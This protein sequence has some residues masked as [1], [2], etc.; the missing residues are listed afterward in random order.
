MVRFNLPDNADR[1]EASTLAKIGQAGRRRIWRRNR[2]GSSHPGEIVKMEKMLVRVDS[3]MQ[4]LPLDYNENDSLKTSSR[5]VE[6]WREFVVVCRESTTN[7]ADFSIQMYKTRVIPSKVDTKVRNRSTHEIPLA[8]KTTHVNL[9]SS[10]D[11]TLVIWV[12]WKMGTMMYILRT[13]S[14]ASAVEWYTFIRNSLGSHRTNVLHVNVPDL[15]VTLQLENPFEELEASINAIQIAATDD[16]AI[17]KTV[18]AERFVLF[19]IF[20]L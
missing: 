20:P 11:K 16:S 6:K 14:I 18:Q 9:Y 4:E 19:Q 7:D 1:G 8:P 3:T 10:L 13:H 2:Q 5:T 12:P 15:S 17:E